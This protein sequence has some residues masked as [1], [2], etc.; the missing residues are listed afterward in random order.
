LC[1]FPLLG[2]TRFRRS[3]PICERAL[4]STAGKQRGDDSF[5][6]LSVA[7]GNVARHLDLESPCPLL[8]RAVV[9]RID[10]T[11]PEAT[12]WRGSRPGRSRLAPRSLCSRGRWCWGRYFSCLKPPLAALRQTGSRP[13]SSRGRGHQHRG[14]A[15]RGAGAGG[16]HA[17][18][19]R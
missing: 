5:N 3:A 2:A 11:A 15:A 9:R 12:T 1:G 19:L 18:D 10:R 17:R 13:R 7:L 14:A 16:A 8:S 6:S 4:D